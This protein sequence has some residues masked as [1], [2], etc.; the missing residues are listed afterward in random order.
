MNDRDERG[1]DILAEE[2]GLGNPGSDQVDIGRE[3]DDEGP[4]GR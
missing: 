2:E 3:N 4:S 1:T